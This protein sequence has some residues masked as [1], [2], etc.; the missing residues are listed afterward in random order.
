LFDKYDTSTSNH[1][2]NEINDWKTDKTTAADGK[3]TVKELME[4]FFG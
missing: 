1:L 2:K 3:S 4:C